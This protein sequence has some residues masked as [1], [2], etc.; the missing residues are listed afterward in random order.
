M[1]YSKGLGA[2]AKGQAG[3]QGFD[4]GLQL[5]QAYQHGVGVVVACDLFAIRPL[6]LKPAPL[7]GEVVAAGAPYFENTGRRKNAL[8]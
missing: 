7:S 1:V 4:L 3:A 8:E 2:V 6:M 5:I